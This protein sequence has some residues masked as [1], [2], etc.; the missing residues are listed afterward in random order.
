M[1]SGAARFT[2]LSILMQSGYPFNGKAV[3]SLAES[4]SL[5]RYGV[6]DR[7]Q[8]VR[9]TA[10]L[11]VTRLIW[12]IPSRRPGSAHEDGFWGSGAAGPVVDRSGSTCWKGTTAYKSRR[13]WAIGPAAT[14][15]A[16]GGTRAPRT[17]GGGAADSPCASRHRGGA[18]HRRVV[19][20]AFRRRGCLP[21]GR[22]LLANRP[23][24]AGCG[25]DLDPPHVSH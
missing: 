4:G 14:N 23:R 17:A 18:N 25:R 21:T 3:F 13:Y 16:G 8:A 9:G 15:G 1:K 19:P 10:R 20:G 5:T 22:R 12:G 11:G 6:R 24:G 7:I 2:L